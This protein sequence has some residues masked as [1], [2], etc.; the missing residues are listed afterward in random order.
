MK[1]DKLGSWFRLPSPLLKFEKK[2]GFVAGVVVQHSAP[3]SR[4]YTV[5]GFETSPKPDGTVD[6]LH[7]FLDNHA[8]AIVA[9]DVQSIA[10]A[11]RLADAWLRRWKRSRKPAAELSDPCTC[12]EIATTEPAKA[13]AA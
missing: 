13:R 3:E 12:G 6:P 9:Q 2:H 5:F 4:T 11:K 1:K 8:H 7:H 10:E